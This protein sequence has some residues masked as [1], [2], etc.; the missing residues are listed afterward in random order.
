MF[1]NLLYKHSFL[2]KPE[3]GT[4]ALCS[5]RFTQN[6]KSIGFSPVFAGEEAPIHTLP[7]E[8]FEEQFDLAQQIIKTSSALEAMALIRKH[9]A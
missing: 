9:T 2:F 4:I 7:G 1:H 8:T 3:I 6:V 5:N